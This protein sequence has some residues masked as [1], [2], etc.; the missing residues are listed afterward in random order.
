[1]E[2]GFIILIVVMTV[3]GVL[4]GLRI[5]IH[6]GTTRR[7]NDDVKGVLT[8]CNSDSDSQPEL[9]LTLMVPAEDVKAEKHVL[10]E[11]HAMK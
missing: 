5:G 11:V 1:M 7:T 4:A 2:T 8:V 3:A 10:F 9:F 6:I